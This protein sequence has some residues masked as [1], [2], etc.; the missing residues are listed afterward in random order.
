MGKELSAIYSPLSDLHRPKHEIFNGDKKSH[1]DTPQRSKSII[2]A[3]QSSKIADLQPFVGHEVKL[4]LETTHDIGYLTYLQSMSRYASRLSEERNDP[5]V[6][7]YPSIHPYTSYARASNSISRRGLYVF[8]TYTPIMGSTYEA[9]IGSAEV[10]LAGA[11]LLL[12]NEPLVY[13]LCRPSG[14]HALRAMA[15]GMCYLNNAAIAANYLKQHGIKKTAVLDIDFHHGNGTQDI[16]YEDPNVLVV[17]IHG[18]PKQTF[19]HFTGYVEE[20]GQG[21]GEGSNFNFPLPAQTDN[22]LYR[23]TALKALDI[24]RRFQPEYLLVSA[25]FDTHESDPIGSF[26]LTT[27]FYQD[28]GKSIKNLDLPVL[29]IQEGGYASDILGLN[30]VSFLSGLLRT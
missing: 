9:A 3:L 8:D 28:L 27:P 21:K 18:D 16:F 10:A 25:G 22:H 19:P 20:T 7:I 11:K 1:Q 30:V 29:V 17:N 6:S 26:G 13:S 14:H 15:G 12:A 5:D 2:Y 24:I 4:Y 23:Q